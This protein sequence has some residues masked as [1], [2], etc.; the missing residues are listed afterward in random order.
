MKNRFRIQPLKPRL[1][2]W[3]VPIVPQGFVAIVL[4]SC[5]SGTAV[6]GY[7]SVSR[8]SPPNFGSLEFGSIAV[9][10]RSAAAISSP[11]P[12]PSP[13]P[14]PSPESLPT[15]S[16]SPE[17]SPE[18]SPVPKPEPTPQTTPEPSPSAATMTTPSPSVEASPIATP[19]GSPAVA[20]PLATPEPSRPATSPPPIAQPETAPADRTY[21]WVESL[22][23]NLRRD[24]AKLTL[25]VKRP[26]GCPGPLVVRQQLLPQRPHPV[27]DPTRDIQM[28]LY[29]ET[30]RSQ[31]C[32]QALVPF[33]FD[34]DLAIPIELGYRYRLQANN[35]RFNLSRDPY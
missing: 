8:R 15:P 33:S 32:T 9:S 21:I 4:W 20:T 10:S 23:V 19:V 34:L 16:P 27:G 2:N 28:D 26:T 13:E 5:L 14:S 3:R 24:R 31:P 25:F 7:H 11:V 1:L 17:P 6:A 22:T 12:N 35:Y 30:P 29:Y 18:P